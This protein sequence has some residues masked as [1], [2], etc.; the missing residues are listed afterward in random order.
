MPKTESKIEK[1]KRIKQT[2][3]YLSCTWYPHEC[4]AV[5]CDLPNEWGGTGPCRDYV[6]EEASV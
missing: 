3:P 2:K 4:N 1:E 6:E 5:G